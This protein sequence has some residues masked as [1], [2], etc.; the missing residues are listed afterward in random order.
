MFVFGILLV[1]AAIVAL[2]WIGVRFIAYMAV[3][4]IA[5]AIAASVLTLVAIPVLLGLAFLLMLLFV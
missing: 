1:L 2:F 3:R 5:F 4:G